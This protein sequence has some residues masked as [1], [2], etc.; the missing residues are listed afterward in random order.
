MLTVLR[1]SGVQQQS[2]L[3]EDSGSE[4]L[5][6]SRVPSAGKFF[7]AWENSV[8]QQLEQGA[9]ILLLIRLGAYLELDF[10]QL[11]DFHRESSGALTQVYDQKSAFEIAVI[12]ANQ[13]Q[14]EKGSYRGRLSALIPYHKRYEFAG[15]SNRL[16]QPQDFRRLV[17]DSL[18][19]RNSIR[20]VG[21]EVS[22]DVWVG[23]GATIDPSARICGPAYIGAHTRVKG[24]C[25]INGGTDIGRDCEID[26]GTTVTDSTV[27]PET[28]LGIGLNVVHSIAAAGFLFNLDRNVEVQISD[29]NLVGKQ[30]TIRTFRKFIAKKDIFNRSE[31]QL[32]GIDSHL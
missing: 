30:R 16:R 29:R 32:S 13:L 12:H 3:F 25:Q 4:N 8:R 7:S 14:G 22:T 19:R 24:Y 5:F 6:P 10:A 21:E 20:P 17:R 2:V 11:L 9:E 28:Y 23:E 15:Y 26:F 18:L 1:D 31:R 27:L